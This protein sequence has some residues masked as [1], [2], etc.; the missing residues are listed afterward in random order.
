MAFNR[1]TFSAVV[2][3]V[4]G[5]GIRMFTYET[6][7]S[8]DAVTVKDYFENLSSFGGRVSDLVF[9]SS[10]AAYSETYLLVI[11]AVSAAGHGTASIATSG[12]T[13]VADFGAKADGVKVAV[14]IFM[15][16]ADTDVFLAGA[17]FTPSDV[18]KSI[19]IPKVGD[20]GG[21]LNTTISKYVSAQQVHVADASGTEVSG[22]ASYLYYGT[23][24]TNAFQRALTFLNNRGGGALSV[25]AG[26]YWFAKDSAPLDPGVGNITILGEGR[27]VSVLMWEGGDVQ[28]N[29]AAA[30]NKCLFQNNVQ[31]TKGYVR[32]EKMT[33]QGA[34]AGASK[35]NSGGVAFWLDF[36]NSVEMIDAE[37]LE[38]KTT[39][40]SVR[41]SERFVSVR[42]RY[43]DIAAG[44]IRAT[45]TFNVLCTGNEILRCGDDA[46]SIHTAAAV[47]ASLGRRPRD[48][49]II[50]DNIITGA[51]GAIKVLG[52]RQVKIHNNISKLTGGGVCVG[53][54]TNEGRNPL[55]DIS[56]C[57][58]TFE[59][60]ILLTSSGTFTN[61]AIGILIQGDPPRGTPSTNNTIPGYYDYTGGVWI[62]PWDYVDVNTQL[63]TTAVTPISGLTI[64]G[65]HMRRTLPAAAAW[66]DYGYGR[67]IRSG[68]YYNGAVSTANFRQNTGISIF[69]GGL[70]DAVISDNIIEH[71]SFGILFGAP[72]TDR[73]YVNVKVTG[74]IVTDCI[75]RGISVA[76]GAHTVDISVEG[77]IVD[78]DPYRAG[79]QSNIDGTYSGS[80]GTRGV[81]AFDNP[82]VSVSGVTFKNCGIAVYATVPVRLDKNVIWCNP[83][84]GTGF[85]TSNKGIGDVPLGGNYL[86][87]IYQC[88][89]TAADYDKIITNPALSAGAMPS[90]GTYVRGHKVIN[91]APS[92][93]GNNMT[94]QNWTRITTGSNHTAGTDWVVA[95]T[96]HV[97]PAT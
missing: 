30:G 65:N 18:G 32:F 64:R 20:G 45:D 49:V 2:Q 40:M 70:K 42:S 24:N 8:T 28:N 5:T 4:G 87:V 25:P 23:D 29:Y 89:P 77:G 69:A 75:A 12:Q 90:T 55:Y 16:A 36:Y 38:A 27:G 73:D 43:Q 81:A 17:A 68:V 31:A 14:T 35:A 74:N 76:A 88:D 80:A 10:A 83:L 59:N 95:R 82:G 97:S 61:N 46:F 60:M 19:S 66:S 94:I 22:D 62:F 78:C 47:Q 9:V 50:S 26:K 63:S 57:D 53:V 33:M 85:S 91:E 56:I 3:S 79:S 44:A 71:L 72:T 37:I 93:D 39:G 48:A 1:E 13:N 7:D 6:D 34:L 58:N 86:H 15:N 92:I 54:D 84:G 96:S 67:G 41:F 52:G 51:G 21:T 11:H